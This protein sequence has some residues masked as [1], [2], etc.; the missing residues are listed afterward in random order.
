[1]KGICALTQNEGEFIKAHLIPRA[2]TRPSSPGQPIMQIASGKKPTRRW[3][4]WYD[5]RLVTIKGENILTEF[6]TWAIQQL[7]AHKLVWSG[8]GEAQTLEGHYSPLPCSP[9][10]IRRISGLDTLRLRLYFLS[11]LWRAAATSRH[12]F[13]EVEISCDDLERLR[14]MLIERN[15]TPAYFYRIQ[16]TQLSTK[17]VIHNMVPVAQYKEVRSSVIGMPHRLQKIFRFYFDGLIVH[18]HLPE[19]EP[20]STDFGSM[21]LGANE[22][23]VLSTVSYEHS[24]ERENLNIVLSESRSMI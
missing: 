24:F 9:W 3:D 7:R 16:L 2:L 19:T 10:G 13:A 22:D 20:T 8:W 5:D 1:M 12:E 21:V 4:S 23:I 11:L 15:A 17:G 14:I 18:I 6:D